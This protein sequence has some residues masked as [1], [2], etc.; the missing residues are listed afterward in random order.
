MSR[1]DYE[2]G[3]VV[4]P[5]TLAPESLKLGGLKFKA[6]LGKMKERR[7]KRKERGR[8]GRLSKTRQDLAKLIL[9]GFI[10]EHSAVLFLAT[11]LSPSPG[12]DIQKEGET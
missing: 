11:T 3:M 7:K 9:Q 12:E 6:T 8:E 10:I 4:L 1:K 2:T 5:V